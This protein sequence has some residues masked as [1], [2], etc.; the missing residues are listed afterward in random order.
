M[1]RVPGR[2][3]A[4]VFAY[5]DELKTWLEQGLSEAAQDLIPKPSEPTPSAPAA[6]IVVPSAPAWPASPL[7]RRLIH[8]AAAVLGLLALV[9]LVASV[10]MAGVSRNASTHAAMRSIAVLPLL[11]LTGDARQ[12]YL[13]AGLTD[14]LIRRNSHA[15]V[16]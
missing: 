12:D 16:R 2:G 5:T 13:A 7:R 9:V 10:M 3:G 11:N 15:S 14:E 4:R 6:A 1:H 8:P